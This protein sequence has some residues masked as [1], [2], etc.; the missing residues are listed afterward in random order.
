M[1]ILRALLPVCLASPAE[2]AAEVAAPSSQALRRRPG[3]RCRL[4]R[5]AL[6]QLPR[7][8]QLA[9]AAPG[10]AAAQSRRAAGPS[11][12][13]WECALERMERTLQGATSHLVT[14][15]SGGTLQTYT[16]PSGV[17][18]CRDTKQCPARRPPW[19]FRG[20][21]Q[22]LHSACGAL[23]ASAPDEV[24][25]VLSLQCAPASESEDWP[26]GVAT[27]CTACAAG[28]LTPFG[29]APAG[30]CVAMLG[31]LCP[32]TAGSAGAG[33]PAPLSCP[34]LYA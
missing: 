28:G 13:L 3:W 25:Q 5:R 6:Q 32:E 1:L 22:Y 2:H 12:P 19:T 27:G 11:G 15:V 7:L 4:S 23:L 17:L 31:G 14:S 9:G 16:L 8:R 18:G 21:E 30:A 33:T 26:S 24:R 29:E 10:S 20:D 34:A